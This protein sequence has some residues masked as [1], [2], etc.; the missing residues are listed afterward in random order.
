MLH[1]FNV[2]KLV[3]VLVNASNHGLGAA[4]L[5]DGKTAAFASKALTPVEQR[6]ATTKSELLL[7]VFSAE[8][9]WIYLYGCHFIAE[10]DNIPLKEI[11]SNTSL[12]HQPNSSTLFHLQGYDFQ[13]THCPRKVMVLL[14]VLSHYACDD[15]G[16]I[17]FNILTTWISPHSTRLACSE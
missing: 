11:L 6:Y 10:L 5:Q 9:F 15:T 1:Y 8:Q 2:Y 3:V 4:L 17:H 12:I 13:L 14:D 7:A 16:E